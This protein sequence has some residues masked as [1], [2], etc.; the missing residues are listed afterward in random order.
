MIFKNFFLVALVLSLLS[1]ASCKK[2]HKDES[3]KENHTEVVE[4]E[5]EI[6]EDTT[7]KIQDFKKETMVETQV[8]NRVTSQEDDKEEEHNSKR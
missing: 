4:E 5:L 8:S 3:V 6:V 1:F 2:N 7:T